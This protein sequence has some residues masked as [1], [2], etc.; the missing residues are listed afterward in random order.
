MG[1]A[2]EREKAQAAMA[3]AVRRIGEAHA[4]MAAT[5]AR[6]VEGGESTADRDAGELHALSN[7]LVELTHMLADGRRA[8]RSAVRS[9]HTRAALAKAQARGDG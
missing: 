8:W 6:M 2:S 7:D 4:A 1:E 3:D 9:E 5:L